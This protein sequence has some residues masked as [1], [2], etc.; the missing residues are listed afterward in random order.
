MPLL[1]AIF[2]TQASAQWLYKSGSCWR[3]GW[4]DLQNGRGLRRPTGSRHLGIA[5]PCHHETRGDVAIVGQPVTLSRTPPE[6]VTMTPEAGEH[7]E[8]VLR[9]LNYSDADIQRLRDAKIV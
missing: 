2:L 3:A 6:I 7:T 8:E 1:D 9:G 4:A 5:V